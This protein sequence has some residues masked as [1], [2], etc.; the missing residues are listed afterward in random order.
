MNPFTV[1]VYY[2]P[3]KLF[4]AVHKGRSVMHQESKLFSKSY[5]NRYWYRNDLKCSIFPKI[6]E[7]KELNVQMTSI[8][9]CAQQIMVQSSKPYYILELK[10]KIRFELV[11][12]FIS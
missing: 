6:M 10:P 2:L 5:T 7:L 3:R 12:I 9:F 1:A 11:G 8:L 4:D